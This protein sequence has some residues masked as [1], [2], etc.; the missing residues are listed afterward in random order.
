MGLIIQKFGYKIRDARMKRTP[1]MII[2][3]AQETEN[4]TYSVRGR[5]QGDMGSM[6]PADFIRMLHEEIDSKAILKPQEIEEQ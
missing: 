4:N 3:G 5:A 1:Y 6:A 2:L